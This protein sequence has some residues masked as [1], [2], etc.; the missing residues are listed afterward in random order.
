MIDIGYLSPTLSPILGLSLPF[1][2]ALLPSPS[3]V[4]ISVGHYEALTRG[5]IV[6]IQSNGQVLTSCDE[7]ALDSLLLTTNTNTHFKIGLHSIIN[8]PLNTQ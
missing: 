6:K 4:Q 7:G 5:V 3:Y 1:H 2:S 8:L